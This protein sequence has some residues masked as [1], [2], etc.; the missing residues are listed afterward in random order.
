M[1][2]EPFILYVVMLCIPIGRIIIHI[3]SLKLMIVWGGNAAIN[4]VAL[5]SKRAYQHK[6]H[7]VQNTEERISRLGRIHYINISMQKKKGA[8]Q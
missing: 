2:G 4:V 3:R 8:H 5:E 1:L 7:I 6:V